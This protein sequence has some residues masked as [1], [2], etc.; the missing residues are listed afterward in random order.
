MLKYVRRFFFLSVREDIFIEVETLLHVFRN[1]FHCLIILV[2]CEP[3]ST[4]T[5]KA[6]D[7]NVLN[8]HT[9]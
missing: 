5:I 3:F 2:V 6:N 7:V 8:L 9:T 1:Y 4:E